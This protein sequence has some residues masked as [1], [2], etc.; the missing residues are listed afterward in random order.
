[1]HINMQNIIFYF[2]SFT[3]EALILWIYSLG[4][5]NFKNKSK[6]LPVLSALYLI[7]FFAAFFEQRELNCVLYI[8][9]NVIFLITQCG[10]RLYTAAF[11]SVMI[12]GLMAMCELITY[13]IFKWFSPHFL[14]LG[15]FRS[16]ILFGISSKITFFAIIYFLIYVLKSKR[17]ED[18]NIQQRRAVLLLGIIPLTSVFVTITFVNIGELDGL[19]PVLGTMVVISAAF[20]LTD[21]ILVFGINEYTRR[22][23]AEYMEMQLLLQKENAM[24]Q[25]YEMLIKQNENQRILIHDIKNHLQSIEL[26]NAQNNN[27]KIT[28]YIN[29]LMQSANFKSA[30]R[31]CDNELL[32]AMLFRYM[33][34]CSENHISF[35]ADI[36]SHVVDFLTDS[37]M[38]TLFCNLLDNALE[39]ADS[40]PDGFIDIS[41]RRRE[42]TRFIV[43]SVT[44]SCRNN[45]LT[46]DS[47]FLPT[48]KSDKAGHG[49]GLK[50]IYR[51]IQKYS[52]DIHMY[53]D[54]DT[55][56]LN[57]IITLKMP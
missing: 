7:L 44:N 49:I 36:R 54:A 33:N 12:T 42:N 35:N 38:T 16:L 2:L 15:S 53:Y 24:K 8:I 46:G 25:Y 39:V 51:V 27:E 50:S 17:Q 14:E 34:E 41:A 4:L 28:E 43:I 3:M 56:A 20:L 52:G 31:L 37:D 18:N 13:A 47:I 26:L 21:N 29:S 5:F 6:A 32:N 57:S 22:K 11:H 9:A 40:I 19:P 55:A 48:T 45:P 10:L 30:L 1:M 23:N